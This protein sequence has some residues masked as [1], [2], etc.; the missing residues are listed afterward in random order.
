MTFKEEVLT[1]S[2]NRSSSTPVFISRS[3]S[4]TTGDNVSCV[5]TRGKLFTGLTSST[6]FAFVSLTVRL[7]IAMTVFRVVVARL[8]TFLMI[9]ASSKRICISRTGEWSLVRS[10]PFI[11][12]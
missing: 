10:W 3:N 4:T 9:F 5:N 8:V 11:S 1:V 6:G 7:V 12:V 2:E